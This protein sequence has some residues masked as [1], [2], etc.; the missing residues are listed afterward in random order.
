MKLT[1]KQ[2]ENYKNKLRTFGP[3]FNLSEAGVFVCESDLTEE[4]V[5]NIVSHLKRAEYVLDAAYTHIFQKNKKQFFIIRGILKESLAEE[6]NETVEIHKKLNPKIWT[7]E[8]ELI[9]EVRAKVL[10]IVDK[11]K[12]QLAV[13]GV[14]L[15]VE[16]IYILGSN[17]NFNYNEDS[18]LDVHIIADES[19]DCSEEHLAI[20]YNCYK[21]LFNNKYDIRIKGI[22][23]E[24]Y[25]ENKANLTNVSAGIYSLKDGW[26][27]VPSEYKIP[28]FDQLAVDKGVQVWEDRYYNITENPSIN[29]I[30]DYINSIYELRQKGIKEGGEFSEGNLVFKEIRRLG[31]LDD[32]KELKTTLTSQEL[33]LEALEEGQEKIRFYYNGPVYH[34]EHLLATNWEAYTEAVSE[35]Q[36][37]NNLTVK[38]KNDFGYVLQSRITL[39]PDYLEV[40]PKLEPDEKFKE[41]PK[42]EKCGRD[43]NDSGECPLCDLGDESVLDEHITPIGRASAEINGIDFENEEVMNGKVKDWMCGDQPYEFQLEDIPDD[44]TWGKLIEAI[45]KGEMHKVLSLDTAPQ[46]HVWQRACE[47]YYLQ[48]GYFADK[49]FE[50]MCKNPEK[51]KWL[52][53]VKFEEDK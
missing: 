8:R 40:S 20:I 21:A 34:F 32:L 6:L 26:I 31:Y 2:I 48:T 16:D 11:F 29:K 43:L 7:E 30:D 36:A 53:L 17:A 44:L 5:K 25:V 42:C 15:K 38:A 52:K 49:D 9:P 12:N 47:L 50:S 28:E 37:L 22:N 51:R 41:A 4:E 18:D 3:D 14:D 33:S 10:Q 13:D 27:R 24:L 39:D 1:P 35:K 45:K 46:E 19:F 23:V